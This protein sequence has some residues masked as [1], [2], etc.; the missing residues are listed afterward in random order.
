MKL[1]A[2]AA[3]V[4]ALAALTQPARADIFVDAGRGPILVNVPPATTRP[5]RRP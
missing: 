3:A 2:L 4:L 5:S 1:P